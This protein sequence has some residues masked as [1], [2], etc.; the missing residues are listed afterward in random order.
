MKTATFKIL[1]SALIILVLQS[2]SDGSNDQNE[3]NSAQQ[4]ENNPEGPQARTAAVG[5]ANIKSYSRPDG[6]SMAIDFE[7]KVG[8][9][10]IKNLNF[11]K[12]LIIDKTH[13]QTILN[14]LDSRE[15]TG[16]MILYPVVNPE[17]GQFSLAIAPAAFATDAEGNYSGGD[18]EVLYINIDGVPSVYEHI[19]PCPTYCSTV[20]SDLYTATD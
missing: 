11:P 20:E 14:E 15:G 18:I 5:S 16:G 3:Q 19:S 17:N 13:L 10:E 7:N 4:S 6:R 8:T 1:I 9:D 2:C 12:S